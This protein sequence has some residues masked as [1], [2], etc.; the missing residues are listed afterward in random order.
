[1][2]YHL[3]QAP[4]AAKPGLTKSA[5]GQYSCGITAE[6]PGYSVRPITILRAYHHNLE[7][8]EMNYSEED[9]KTKI[10]EILSRMKE[11]D[12]VEV[13]KVRDVVKANVSFF[14]RSAFAAYLLMEAMNKPAKPERPPRAERPRRE[15]PQAAP[16]PEAEAGS[17]EASAEEKKEEKPARPE[18]TPKPVPEGAKTI[19]ID[20]GKM[21]HLYPKDLSKLLQ[22]ELGIT[23]DDIYMIRVHD[24]YSFVTMT[25]ENC[26]KAIEKLNGK[27]ING[28]IAKVSL[29]NR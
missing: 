24:K 7:I 11:A 8:K 26:Q 1:M 12:P 17:A 14:N 28:R 4:R 21:K 15:R 23:R 18:R 13:E 6:V 3:P 9:L 20:V 25:E 29:S 10:S 22:F 2:S 27:D 5:L 16:A 19:Y